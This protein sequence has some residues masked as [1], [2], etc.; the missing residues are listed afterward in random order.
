M[1]VVALKGV[2]RKYGNIVA[3]DCLDLVVEKGEFLT[4]LGPSGSGK[5]T[6]LNI[7]AGMIP[8]SS[9]RVEIDGR[10]VTDM[11]T[12]QRG[13]GMVFQNYALMPHMTVFD[14]IAFPLRVRRVREPEIRTRVAEALDIV[15]L[16]DLGGRKPRELSGGQQQRVAIARC[17]VYKPSL[18]LMDEPLG[19]LDKK[20]RE[21]LQLE[22]KRLHSDLGVTIVYVT[23]DQE[24][25]LTLS[26]RICLMNTGRIEQLGTPHELYFA[27]Q[28]VFGAQFLGESNVLNATVSESSCEK[29]VLRCPIGT[30][31]AP[32]TSIATGAEVT[33]VV[34]PENIRRLRPDE[35]IG[36]ELSGELIDTTFV[37]GVT[38][39][40]V[41]SDNGG[42]LVL[43]E[44]TNQT[45]WAAGSERVRIGW[46]A[47]QTLVIQNA[48][49]R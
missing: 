17:L 41:R 46:P 31:R 13:L 12:R 45:P 27:P 39:Y 8:P 42:V 20:L 10:D 11:P 22:I 24:E 3:L 44:L 21:Q 7:I 34:R 37:G 26:D 5:T 15:N 28:T 1:T 14:N 4:L 19:A 40:Y 43:K 30:I 36:N 35:H 2:S 38:R 25:A 32:G 47:E 33:I 18:I 49:R 23:H 48:S 29:T 9:G 6:L 16:R